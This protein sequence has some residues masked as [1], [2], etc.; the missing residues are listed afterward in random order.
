MTLKS[1]R[2]LLMCDLDLSISK[3]VFKARGK[4]D[5]RTKKQRGFEREEY[6]E[7]G[8]NLSL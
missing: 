1:P 7:R 4:N 6:K 3:E 2:P 8:N 5:S